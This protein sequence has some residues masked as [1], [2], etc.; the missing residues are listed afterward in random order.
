METCERHAHYR[1]NSEHLKIRF[2]SFLFIIYR[3]IGSRKKN[4]QCLSLFV[5]IIF[6]RMYRVT[7]DLKLWT[8][9]IRTRGCSYE[10]GHTDRPNQK[11]T[12]ANQQILTHY[13]VACAELETGKQSRIFGEVKDGGRK[14]RKKSAASIFRRRK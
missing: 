11:C 10:R 12:N 1:S 7:I 8:L 2:S 9:C 3:Y 4:R 6:R 13:T 5:I 14:K